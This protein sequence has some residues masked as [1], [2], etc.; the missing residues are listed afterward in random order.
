MKE[1]YKKLNRWVMVIMLV[2]LAPLAVRAADAINITGAGA[3]FPYPLYSKWFFEYKK[4]HP[5]IKFNY[6]S[7]GSGG[8]IQQIIAKTVDFG[9]SD[10]PMSDDDLKKTGDAKLLHIPTILGAVVASY[11]LPEV[12]ADLKLNS[13]VL[14]DIFRGV[15]KKWNDAKIAALNPGKTLPSQDILVAYRSDGSGTTYV[16]TDYLSKVSP[17]WKSGVGTGK[18]VKWPVGLG[19]KGNEGVSGLIKQ[20][21]GAIGY[22][23]LSYALENKLAYATL[24]NKAGKFVT[25]SMEAVS[26]AAAAMESAIPAD[27]RV[28]IINADGEKSYP[29][30]AFTYLLVYETQTNGTKGA[31]L[32]DFLKWA[33]QDG[34]K[35]APALHYAPLPASLAQKVET[36]ISQIKIA[37]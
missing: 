14:S 7:I 5:H 18:S 21:P 22:V 15:V 36:T 29:I 35:I 10:A 28:S 13:A 27:Y 19:A 31:A 33:L 24:E 30:S 23:E 20:T 37:K 2:I 34:Q 16:F 9:A 25:P 8:G 11:N 4:T 1:I 6:Q 12:G 3:T 32:V 17:E 26:A